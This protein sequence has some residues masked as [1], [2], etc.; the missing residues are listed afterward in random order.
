MFNICLMKLNI[1]VEILQSIAVLLTCFSKAL[2][3]GRETKR[4]LN[5]AHVNKSLLENAYWLCSQ[6]TAH[7]FGGRNRLFLETHCRG[8]S[9]FIYCR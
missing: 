2:R 3:Q 1:Y 5:L 4:N 9:V 7:R 6:K 8:Q